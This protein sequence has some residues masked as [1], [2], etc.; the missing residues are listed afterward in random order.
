MWP[1]TCSVAPL[2]MQFPFLDNALDDPGV[3]QPLAPC[4]V[5]VLPAH[6]AV[7]HRRRALGHLRQQLVEQLGAQAHYDLAMAAPVGRAREDLRLDVQH[8]FGRF[9]EGLPRLLALGR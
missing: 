1:K 3:L 9:R 2:S 5:L 4:G 6:F 7:E 8:L